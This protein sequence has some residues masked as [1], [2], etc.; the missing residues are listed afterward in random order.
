MGAVRPAGDNGRMENSWHPDGL[1]VLV[2]QTAR[3]YGVDRSL[4]RI[5]IIVTTDHGQLEVQSIGGSSEHPTIRLLDMAD[6][7]HMVREDRILSI[8]FSRPTQPAEGKP[9]VGF[10]VEPHA[11]D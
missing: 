2:Q 3:R 1:A 5:T 6:N 9:A 4:S 11:D 10:V 8:T 7:V